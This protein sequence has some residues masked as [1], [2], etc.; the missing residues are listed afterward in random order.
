MCELPSRW[1][2]FVPVFTGIVNLH[3]ALSVA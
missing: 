1:L 2:R 3:R